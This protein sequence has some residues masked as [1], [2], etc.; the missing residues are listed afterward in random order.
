MRTPN[1]V[2]NPI[3]AT[4]QYFVNDLDLGSCI[5]ESRSGTAGS[6]KR[7]SWWGTQLRRRVPDTADSTG[8]LGNLLMEAEKSR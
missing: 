2:L 1:K 4:S 5:D 7:G 3:Q 6:R 8:R